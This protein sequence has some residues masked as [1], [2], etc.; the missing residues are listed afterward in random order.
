MPI[1]FLECGDPHYG[2]TR[3]YCDGCGQ[4]SLLAFSGKT[5]TFLGLRTTYRHDRTARDRRRIE[6][7]IR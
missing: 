1:F 2:F 4:D 6:M 5:R 7:R 3:V